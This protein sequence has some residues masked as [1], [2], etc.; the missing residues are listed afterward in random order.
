MLKKTHTESVSGYLRHN[1]VSRDDVLHLLGPRVHKAEPSAPQRNER[2]VFDFE[3]VT[4]GVDLFSHLQHC[5]RWECIMSA[6]ARAKYLFLMAGTFRKHTLSVTLRQ[7]ADVVLV[8]IL[9]E[10][11]S[12][13]LLGQIR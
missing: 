4:V 8:E 1:G 13:Q 2:T 5:E 6:T 9:V 11:R 3:F 12:Q 10:G 7:V